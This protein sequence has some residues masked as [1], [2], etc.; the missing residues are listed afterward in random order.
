MTTHSDI[1]TLLVN[2]AAWQQATE[3][4]DKTFFQKSTQ[5]QSPKLLWIGCVDSRVPPEVICGLEPGEMLTHRNIA[6][7]VPTRDINSNAIVEFGIGVLKIP[8]IVVCGHTACGGIK[9][10]IGLAKSGGAGVGTPLTNWV[11]PLGELFTANQESL[12]SLSDSDQADQL[13]AINVKE[14]IA[15][16]CNHE[17]VKKAWEENQP[18]AIHGMVFHLGSGR[19]E[20]LD[21]SISHNQ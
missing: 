1:E 21:V 14:Q 16:L 12:A 2:N 9:A 8:H 17:T 3:K 13:A 18:L 19:L 11:T 5:G 20:D 7:Q 10:G 4:A 15:S 6:N